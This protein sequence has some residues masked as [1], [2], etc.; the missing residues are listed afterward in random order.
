MFHV[1]EEIDGVGFCTDREGRVWD[2]KDGDCN[3]FYDDFVLC[4]ILDNCP[5]E[6]IVEPD[7]EP[8]DEEEEEIPE[9]EEEQCFDEPEAETVF[10][11]FCALEASMYRTIFYLSDSNEDKSVTFLEMLFFLGGFDL[12]ND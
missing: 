10:Y 7:P 2:P 5:V 6:E 9:P 1:F 4:E 8:E 11:E 3:W 12:D